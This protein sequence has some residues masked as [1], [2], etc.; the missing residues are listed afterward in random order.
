MADEK[1]ERYISDIVNAI[2]TAKKEA[3]EEGRAEGRDERSL[4]IARKMKAKGKSI[5]EIAE[6]TDLTIEEISRL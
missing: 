3:K 4:E 2:N 6:L 1:R 5:Q